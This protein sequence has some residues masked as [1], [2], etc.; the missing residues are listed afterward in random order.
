[1]ARPNPASACVEVGTCTPQHH[2]SR[3]SAPCTSLPTPPSAP[4]TSVPTPNPTGAPSPRAAQ[5]S[6]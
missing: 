1:M 5:S 6:P 2:P 3:P 4:C